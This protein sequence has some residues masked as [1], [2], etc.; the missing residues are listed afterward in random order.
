[1]SFRPVRVGI[2]EEPEEVETVA[3]TSVEQR[4][5][6]Y[7]FIIFSVKG[8]FVGLKPTGL[9]PQSCSV[10]QRPNPNGV[11]EDDSLSLQDGKTFQNMY[12]R[13]FGDIS[14][15]SVSWTHD[16]MHWISSM[17]ARMRSEGC[18]QYSV[19]YNDHWQDL[20][21]FNVENLAT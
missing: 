10:Y 21:T 9:P 16:L 13:I 11:V 6:F 3:W 17:L 4:G 7:G 8:S 1:M 15:F 14:C 20:L 12:K 18:S 5:H 19:R 2:E